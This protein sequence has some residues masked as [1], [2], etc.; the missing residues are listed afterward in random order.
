MV[1][2]RRLVHGTG[3]EAPLVQMT[4]SRQV[5]AVLRTQTVL[6]TLCLPL[7][8][9]CLQGH[10][11]EMFKRAGW[12]EEGTDKWLQVSTAHSCCRFHDR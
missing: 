3:G 8:E 4:V 1:V 10:G 5:G 11:T 12:G 6:S 2:G 7:E 9:P